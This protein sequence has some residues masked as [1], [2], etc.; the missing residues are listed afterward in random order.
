MIAGCQ[1]NGRVFFRRLLSLTGRSEQG[2]NQ[3]RDGTQLQNPGSE[4]LVSPD[5]SLQL[6]GCVPLSMS[7]IHRKGQNISWSQMERKEKGQQQ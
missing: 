4:V 7:S 6:S 3:D 2:T 5:L 1:S